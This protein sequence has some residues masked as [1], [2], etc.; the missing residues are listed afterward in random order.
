MNTGG[1]GSV[2][3]NMGSSAGNMGGVGSS[4]TCVSTGDSK[5]SGRGSRT[6]VGALGVEEIWF[7]QRVRAK[8]TPSVITSS[9]L[10]NFSFLLVQ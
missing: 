6:Q 3:T 2:R 9:S 4:A 10:A 5:L 8:Y 7:P 1:T